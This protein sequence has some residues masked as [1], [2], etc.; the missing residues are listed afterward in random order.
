MK[1]LSAAEPQVP[2]LTRDRARG[3]RRASTDAEQKLWAHLRNRQ[4]RGAKF[5]R[6]H[7]IGPYIA[8]FFCL[9]AKLIVEVDGGGH[10]TE[11]QRRADA[12][13]AAYLENCGYRVLRFWNNEVIGNIDG[14]LERIAEFL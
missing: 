5:R 13:R 10:A 8:D 7:P 4:L 3:L 9:E 11:A 2:P 1:N 6:E 12:A 14:V